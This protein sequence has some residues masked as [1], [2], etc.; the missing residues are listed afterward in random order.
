MSVLIA[1]TLTLASFAF[2]ITY[3]GTTSLAGLLS[4]WC[5]FITWGGYFANGADANSVKVTLGGS[6]LGVVLGCICVACILSIP[7]GSLNIP[8]WVAI[9]VAIFTYM[10]KIPL[11]AALPST[12]NGFGCVFAYVLQTEGMLSMGVLTGFNFTNPAILLTVSVIAGVAIG[13]A[14][15]KVTGLIAASE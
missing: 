1:L 8:L 15:N 11:F 6:I 5:L 13:V 9:F 14:S 4:L 3:L 12:V 2:G 10:S 7:L